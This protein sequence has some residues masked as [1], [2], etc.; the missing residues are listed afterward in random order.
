MMKLNPIFC[1]TTTIKIIY[2]MLN[3][4]VE[5]KFIYSAIKYQ[6]LPAIT[7]TKKKTVFKHLFCKQ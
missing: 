3:K 1:S 5:T 7:T 4:K 2:F 6:F